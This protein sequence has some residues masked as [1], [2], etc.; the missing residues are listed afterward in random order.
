MSYQGLIAEIPLGQEGMT[1]SKNLSQIKPTQLIRARAITYENGTLEK[2]GGDTLYNATPIAGAPTIRGGWD[3]WPTTGIQRMVVM[4]SDGRVYKD[5]GSGTFPVTLAAGLTSAAVV[6]V[7]VEGGREAATNPRKLFLTTGKNQVRVLSGDGV[8]MTPIRIPPADWTGT[9]FPKTG[10]IHES[11]FWAFMSDTAYYSTTTDHEDFAGPTSGILPIYPGEGEEIVAAFVFG[12]FIICLK[13]PAGWYL[14]DT[15]DPN[16]G[17]WKVS[18]ITRQ[19]AI[20][21]PLAFAIVEGDAMVVDVSG[22][23]FALSAISQQVDGRPRSVTQEALF[24]P[25]IRANTNASQYGKIQGIYYPAKRQSWFA[26]AGAGATTNTYRI[27]TDLLSGVLKFAFSDVVV[28]ESLWLRKDANGIPRPMAGDH[29]GTVRY[30][31]QEARAHDGGGYQGEFQ[32]PHTDLAFVDL[33]LA[34]RRKN[35]QFLELVFEPQGNWN[36]FIDVI[37]DGRLNETLTFPM[38][39]GGTILGITSTLD[40]D[41][42]LGGDSVKTIRKRITGS[43]RRF[44]MVGRNSGAGQSFSV[45]K[46]YLHFTAGDER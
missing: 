38:G 42:I 32:T 9:T 24:S 37:W 20:A 44:S 14:I 29:Q 25:W 27:K 46:A 31:D 30:L 45:A 34:V 35:G 18:R 23:I 39:G 3:W 4:G 19:I 21:G 41:F 8:T 6:P 10:L 33:A 2:E 5:D 7:F 15:S 17:N 26:V 36:L 11:R 43:G 13:Q 16:V 28:C 1:G 12:P 22:D 40:V